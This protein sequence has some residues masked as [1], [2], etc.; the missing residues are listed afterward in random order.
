MLLL[1]H[2]MLNG[3]L[4][5]TSPS[6]I[7]DALLPIEAKLDADG[8]RILMFSHVLDHA[9]EIAHVPDSDQLEFQVDG[10]AQEED[11]TRLLKHH[12]TPSH[13]EVLDEAAHRRNPLRI[14]TDR[15]PPIDTYQ[16]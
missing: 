7:L 12:S 9:G 1:Q 5:A 4:Y 11:E 16:E 14:D 8:F 13:T 2:G 10:G 15:P 3:F 6:A